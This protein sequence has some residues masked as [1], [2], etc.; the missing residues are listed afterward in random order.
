M[1][2]PTAPLA[3]LG[4]SPRIWEWQG[5]RIAL[6]EAGS[7]SPVLLVHSINA[8]ASAHEMRHPFA[9]LARDHRVIA[10]DLLGFGDSDRPQRI[11]TAELYIE[12]LIALAEHIGVPVMVVA[13]S[14][15][16][17][18]VL[19]AMARRP[20]LFCA[21]SVVCPTGLE[22]LVVPAVPT[23]AYRVLAGP[24]GAAVFSALVS[25]RSI[26]YFLSRMTYAN[27][28][29]CDAEMRRMYYQTAQRPGARWAPIC[30]VTGLLNCDV[31]P[32]VAQIQ[33]PVQIMWGRQAG[34]TPVQRM[35]AFQRQLPSVDTV[36]L[37]AG[38]A[39]Q[40]EVPHD[41]YREFSRF[42]KE[43]KA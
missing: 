33:Q 43:V 15:S 42:M 3:L 2:N 17:A 13:V 35:A 1:N 26:D 27:P 32:V 9:M 38:M 19:Q 4:V 14:L 5:H 22:D 37:E 7:G 16:S 25:R 6:H 39:V 28:A 12:L 11:Y 24:V 34:T 21:A 10:V 30:F 40:D 29:A 18:Y 23:G 41:W 20:E 36:V 31:R 8:A